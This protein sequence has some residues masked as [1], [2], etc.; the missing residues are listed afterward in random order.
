MAIVQMQKFHVLTFKKTHEKLLQTLQNFQKVEILPADEGIL[1]SDNHFVKDDSSIQ[2]DKLENQLA[3][4]LWAKEFLTNYVPQKSFIQKLRNQSPTYTLAQLEQIT[5]TSDWES[6]VEDLRAKDRRLRMISQEKQDLSKEENELNRWRYFD[7][8]PAVLNDLKHSVGLLGTISNEQIPTLNHE[9]EKYPSS[10]YQ[11]IQ[12]TNSTTYLLLLFHKTNEKKVQYSLATVG[13]NEYHYPFQGKPQEAL[14]EIKDKIAAIV[15]EE[16]AIKDALRQMQAEEIQLNVVAEYYSSKV[17]QSR[18]KE[19]LFQS[20]AVTSLAGWIPKTQAQAL[21]AQISQVTK[22]DYY[23]VFEE[24]R[25]EEIDEVPIL[26][27]NNRWVAPFETLIEMYSLPKYNEIDPTPFMAPFYALAFGMMVAD[28]GYGLFLFLAILLI[29]KIFYFDASMK[30]SLTFFQLCAIPTMMWG[31][32]YGSFFGMTM[33]FQLLSNQSDITEILIISVIFGYIQ[34]FFAL[35]LK[36]YVLWAKKEQK[37]KAVFQAGSWMLFLFSVGLLA[38]GFMV[39][40]E[41]SL[42]T[43]G[44][45]GLVISLISV[46][47]GG[48]TEGETFVGK[49]GTGLYSLMDLTNYMSDLVSYTRLMALGVAGGSIAA[50]FNLIISYFPTAARFTIGAVLF[51]LLHAINIFLSY[52]SAYVHGIRL[53]YLEFFGKFFTGGGRAFKPFKASNKYVTIVSDEK[54]QQEEQ[55]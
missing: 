32:I 14:S 17:I 48:S 41:T 3:R 15:A 12:Q 21:E 25:E 16:K 27:E 22:G 34:I 44:S 2:T 9:L 46:V 28:F 6:F 49:I 47:I 20:K 37:F 7:E 1:L 43:I 26:L 38:L 50:A 39:L 55:Q 11:I 10:Y 30:R 13:F 24:V 51:V 23:L 54:K 53:Q 5:E 31:L 45:I 42:G 4:V 8:S 29:K 18:N 40:P 52:L 19:R 36:F 33:P 35:I